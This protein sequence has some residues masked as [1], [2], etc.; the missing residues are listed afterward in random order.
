MKNRIIR[1]STFVILLVFS[2]IAFN[3]S[4]AQDF[5]GKE[6]QL[7]VGKDVKAKEFKEDW[8]KNYHYKN[9]YKKFDVKN[10]KLD[11]F[12]TRPFA[13][14]L[15]T[16]YSKLVGKE[17][18]VKNYYE[19]TERYIML[20]LSNDKIGTLFYEYDPKYE[21]DYE[22]TVIG[23]L[24]LPEDFY[25]RD[26]EKEVDKFTNKIKYNTPTENGMYYN[27]YIEDGSVR[28]YLL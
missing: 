3:Q 14:N 6:V 21:R 20:E 27:K 16:E 4:E 17:F 25:C 18:K 15:Y 9:F 10:K 8:E 24:V 2:I 13:K 23:G 19:T 7:L 28:I 5:P 12:R 11:K 1:T 22:L 26:I